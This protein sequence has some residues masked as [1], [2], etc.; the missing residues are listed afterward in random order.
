[1]TIAAVFFISCS[2]AGVRPG[3]D[4]LSGDWVNDKG[5]VVRIHRLEDTRLGAEIISAPGFFAKDVGA[6]NVVLRNI[7]PYSDGYAA[8]FIMPG[9][10]RPVRVLIRFLDAGTLIFQSSDKRVQGN[11]MIWK[12]APKENT[13]PK[14]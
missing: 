1:M 5:I 2:P 8:D 9:K 3:M 4:S 10:E 12:R 6:G 14:S 7:S 13:A 11:R